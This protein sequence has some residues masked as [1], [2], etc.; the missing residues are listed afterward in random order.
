M[1]FFNLLIV[2]CLLL[3]SGC[4]TNQP[5]QI[6]MMML[7]NRL[8]QLEE[9]KKIEEQKVLV[10]IIVKDGS[11]EGYKKVTIEAILNED[12]QLII[13]QDKVIRKFELKSTDDNS[14]IK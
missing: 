9:S 11:K 4:V 6:T 2:G 13:P 1:K 10:E 7:S 5:D 12:G 3:I 8:A 14:R